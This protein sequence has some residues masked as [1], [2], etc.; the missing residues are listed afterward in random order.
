MIYI[1]FLSFKNIVY[2]YLKFS[3]IIL[4][5]INVR[6]FKF[7]KNINKFLCIMM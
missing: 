1:S 2:Y 5:Y 3:K 4:I 6:I 7:I